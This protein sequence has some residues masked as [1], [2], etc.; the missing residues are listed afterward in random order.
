MGG[1]PKPAGP[2]A[3]QQELEDLQITLMQKQLD[4]L[5]KPPQKIQLPKPIPPPP[6]PAMVSGDT[7]AAANAAR[8]QAMRRT[9]TAQKT[10]FA[11]ETGGYQAKTLLG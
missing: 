4:E 6:P 10:L 5:N 3:K 9:N 8:A 1:A 2:S 7:E 11:G